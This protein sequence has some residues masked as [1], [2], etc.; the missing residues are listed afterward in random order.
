MRVNLSSVNVPLPPWTLLLVAE[1]LLFLGLGIGLWGSMSLQPSNSSVAFF[2]IAAFLSLVGGA[3]LW[4]ISRR[5]QPRRLEQR[6]LSKALDLN[7]SF[8]AW[9]RHRRQTTLWATASLQSEALVVQGRSRLELKAG[10]GLIIEHWEGDDLEVELITGESESERS[11][12]SSGQV[13]RAEAGPE[14]AQILISVPADA[15]EGARI[16]LHRLPQP[17]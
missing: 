15:R 6:G 12:L 11:H 16:L 10:E 1:G 13:A 2:L 9:I 14:A 7:D 3:S 17:W 8:T 5:R 4:V